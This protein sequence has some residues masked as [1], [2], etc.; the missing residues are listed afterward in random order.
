MVVLRCCPDKSLA[1]DLASK[2][3]ELAK[4]VLSDTASRVKAGGGAGVKEEKDDE[5]ND[6][7]GQSSLRQLDPYL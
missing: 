3:T 6:N 1:S 4:I 2:T 5:E 7:V